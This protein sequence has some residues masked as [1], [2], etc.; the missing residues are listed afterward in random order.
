MTE[1]SIETR[2][3]YVVAVEDLAKRLRRDLELAVSKA[4]PVEMTPD[5]EHVPTPEQRI[6]GLEKVLKAA[7]VALRTAA[8]EREKAGRLIETLTAE[9]QHLRAQAAASDERYLHY[10]GETERLCR[11]ELV[12]NDAMANLTAERDARGEM[13]DALTDKL[14]ERDAAIERLIKRIDVI[15]H[16]SDLTAEWP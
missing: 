2:E 4:Q 15:R 5:L 14:A 1:T 3:Q 8:E 7:E 16:A 13:I 11:A 9:N 12:R 6:D 10:K